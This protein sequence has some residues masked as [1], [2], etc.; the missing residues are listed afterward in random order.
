MLPLKPTRLLSARPPRLHRRNPPRKLLMRAA[1]RLVAILTAFLPQ[2]R[3][4][5]RRSPSPQQLR[6]RLLTINRQ[7]LKSLYQANT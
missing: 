7:H 3:Q 2:E 4:A 6:K 1:R 5:L